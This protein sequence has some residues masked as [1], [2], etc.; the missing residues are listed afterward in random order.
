[1]KAGFL[2]RQTRLAA[3]L[4]I[5]ATTATLKKNATIACD[6]TRCRNSFELMLTSEVCEAAPIEVAAF[7]GN[8]VE[9]LALLSS[10]WSKPPKGFYCKCCTCEQYERPQLHT[11]Q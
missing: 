5:R 7:R 9:G 8:A 6:V 10:V 3:K 1:V 2:W 11:D 4:I